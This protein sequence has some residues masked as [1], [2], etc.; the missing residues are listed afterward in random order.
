M[1][2]QRQWVPHGGDSKVEGE[3]Q[4]IYFHRSRL[5]KQPMRPFHKATK[6]DVLIYLYLQ[7]EA[8]N[9]TGQRFAVLFKLITLVGIIN[10]LTG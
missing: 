9:L 8:I 6:S 4:R 7:R 1:W 3:R 5:W 10:S 2:A